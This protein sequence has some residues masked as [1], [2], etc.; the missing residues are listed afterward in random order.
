MIMEKM[1]DFDRF[2]IDEL[3]ASVS[4]EAAADPSLAAAIE[5]ARMLQE[6]LDELV[7]LRKR[8]GLT[9]TDVARLMG[10]RQ[11]TVSQFETESSDPR[12]STL[13]RYARAVGSQVVWQVSFWMGDYAPSTGY[14]TK[15]D[16]ADVRPH[17]VTVS[18][19]SLALDWAVENG[20]A[21]F[22]LAA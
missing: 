15:A 6:L 7:R 14:A 13:Q 9:Q 2:E 5:D 22:S 1:P 4:A 11:P 16:S 21:D 12:I 20:R 18:R 10:V 3:S 8:A 17:K 19:K